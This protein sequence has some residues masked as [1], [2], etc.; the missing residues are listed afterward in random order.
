MNKAVELRLRELWDQCCAKQAEL[1]ASVS[2]L[3]VARLLSQLRADT[4]QAVL[5][6]HFWYK[7]YG[8]RQFSGPSAPVNVTGLLREKALPL[9]ERLNHLLQ[10]KH[11]TG[12]SVNPCNHKL[13]GTVHRSY[14]RC[15]AAGEKNHFFFQI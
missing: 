1:D 4:A 14:F 8:L 7:E 2:S 15:Q 11:Y 6:G 12:L 13:S 3:H 10:D 9:L 5:T